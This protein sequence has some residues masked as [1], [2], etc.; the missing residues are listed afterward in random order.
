MNAMQMGPRGHRQIGTIW[1]Y[2][3]AAVFLGATIFMVVFALAEQDVWEARRAALPA[4]VAVLLAGLPA[5]R[6]WWHDRRAAVELAD[7][8]ERTRGRY[9]AQ[10]EEERSRREREARE[11]E[12][13]LREERSARLRAESA[14]RA[15]RE[16]NRE[17]RSQIV[18]MHHERG[19]LGDWDDVRALVLHI[20]IT[21]LEAEKGLLFSRRDDDNDGDLD[22]VCAE[23]FESSPEH[24]ELAQRFASQVIENDQTIRETR[25]SEVEEERSTPA[26]REIHNL[27]AI[28]I[29]IRES[30][31]GVVVCANNEND[32]EDFED[33]ILLALGDHAGAVLDNGK[34]HG[35][36][37]T[38]YV[39][40]VRMLAEA[41]E[42]KAPF[43]RGHSEEVSS[44]VAAVARR[45]E[46]E[47]T[48]REEI[49]F[50]SL[51]HDVGKI[52]ISERILLKPGALTP[53]EY[54]VIQ[55]HPRIGYRLV[56]QVPSLQPIAKAILHH[57]EC[58]D[59]TGYPSRLR[60]E[61]IPLEARII[62]VADSFSAMTTERPYRGRMSLDEACAELERCAGTQF[63]PEIVRIFCEEV[64]GKPRVEEKPTELQQ[65]LSDPELTERLD[66]AE[67]LLGYGSFA[68]TDN[69][70]LL[71]SHRYFHEVA[72]AEA[73]R[74]AVQDAGFAVILVEVA[75]VSEINR[76]DGY[77]AGDEAI[78]QAARAVARAAVR[79]GGTAARYSG[80]RLG[81]IAPKA[82]DKAAERI[83]SEISADLAEGPAVR[84]A[85][86][87]WQAGEGGEDVIARARLRLAPVGVAPPAV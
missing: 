39:S 37:R 23:N 78:R 86:S 58:Y 63:D 64:R 46:I 67:P 71:Y 34:L 5:L 84:C 66:E 30:F 70:T 53:E 76:G 60:G 83:A 74:A 57:H 82:D 85:S 36:L 51:L 18:R 7:A 55:L 32:F 59:G 75:D 12:Q 44:Y 43:L 8:D 24:S 61:E 19:A 33:E 79:C 27:V 35:A 72:H 6:G 26:D 42:A 56:Q 38:S 52:G 14:R 16:W 20:A 87:C 68:V 25:D 10:L 3:A 1:F 29:Y 81:V 69:L 48:R 15:E 31:S 45:L 47:A 54:S 2:L 77:V 73:N 11:H 80:R 21:L 62:C 4:L 22:L 40:T 50:G 41:L 9:E 13:G 49:V 28:P 65:A 17:L